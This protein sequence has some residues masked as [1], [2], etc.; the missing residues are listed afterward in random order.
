MIFYMSIYERLIIQEHCTCMHYINFTDALR[1]VEAP[2]QLLKV[3]VKC[4][5][6]G[7]FSVTRM[8]LLFLLVL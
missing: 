7:D 8:M 4:T 1:Y 6:H 2:N 3:R 5:V